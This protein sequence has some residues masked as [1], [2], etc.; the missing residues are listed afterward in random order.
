[1]TSRSA[2]RAAEAAARLPGAIGI[3]CD[4]RDEASVAR[5]VE[6]AWSRLGGIDMLV[7]N[8]GIGMRTVNP[9]FL[10]EP[11]PFWKVS[12]DGFRAVI[13]TNLTGY[14]LVAREV[15]PRMLVAGHGRIANISMNHATMTRAG[16]VP[17]GPSR[18][19]AESLSRIMAADLRGSG[20]V[21]NMLLP[22]GATRTG[23]VPP[24]GD[25]LPLLDPGIMGPP[26]VWLASAEA[27]DV[28]DERIVATEFADWLQRRQA[29]QSSLQKL[30]EPEDVADAGL[31]LDPS[32]QPGP[33]EGADVLGQLH[34]HDAA[35]RHPNV[36]R[37][38]GRA[39]FADRFRYTTRPEPGG[40]R[41][42]Q[43][44]N[45]AGER[46]PGEEGVALFRVQL[47]EP[48]GQLLECLAAFL[49]RGHRGFTPR[50]VGTVAFNAEVNAD[51]DDQG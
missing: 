22:G 15:T 5:A 2:E 21:V 23:M 26:I 39:R 29:R 35:G 43:V 25:D 6:E 10:S 44:G 51:G 42:G 36:R 37:P 12:P 1:V 46:A 48:P 7:N 38:A 20:I 32:G 33:G 11:Q 45:A 18:A 28:H 50:I 41:D 47:S 49:G 14:F 8:A 19:G 4:V 30:A 16:F 17:Y 31:H 34:D 13:D 40:E 3:E 24:G 9:R 27:G